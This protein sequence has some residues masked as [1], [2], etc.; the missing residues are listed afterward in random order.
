MSSSNPPFGFFDPDMLATLEQTF[1][2]TW[3]V[4]EAHEPFLDSEKEAELKLGL[5]RTL[6]ALVAEGVTDADRLRK[7][8]LER[9]PLTPQAPPKID[10]H[11]LGR[12]PIADD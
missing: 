3:P 1:N 9:L 10:G 8:A 12:A 4:L 6:V 7:F 2:A 11:H 5:S